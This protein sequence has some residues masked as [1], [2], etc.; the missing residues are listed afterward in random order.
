MAD[1]AL[2]ALA[3]LVGENNFAVRA[4]VDQSLVSEDKAM[5]KELEEDP[6][7]PLVIVILG[8]IY[9][10]GPVK[11]ESNAFKLIG[12]L[13][14]V[15]IGDHAGMR[16]CLDGIV[17]GRQAKCVIADREQ[18]VVTLHPALSGQHFHAAVCFDMT[19]MHAGSTGVRELDQPVELGLV[20]EILRLEEFGIF[21]L[22]LP[23][24]F[25][26]LKIVFHDSPHF[27]ALPLLYFYSFP[28][29]ISFSPE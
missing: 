21:P 2:A 5:I 7:G 19:D 25:N 3:V 8:R 29:A 16:V 10:S 15:G 26:L 17:L 28:D 4:I 1:V 9:R 12:K 24:G 18:D 14:N 11:G 23:L 6:L 22:F 20:T 13:R 27:G